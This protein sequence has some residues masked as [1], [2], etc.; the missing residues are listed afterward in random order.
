MR[1]CFLLAVLAL[2]STLSSPAVRAQAPPPWS[3]YPLGVG[4]VWEYAEPGTGN[5]L[6]VHIARDT[7]ALGRPYVVQV[8]DRFD[9][10]GDTLPPPLYYHRTPLRYDTASTQVRNIIPLDPDEEQVFPFAPCPLGAPGGQ[11]VRCYD[12]AS[13]YGVREFIGTLTI[14]DTVLTGVRFKEFESTAELFTYAAE[15]GEVEFLSKIEPYRYLRYARVGG[16][17]YGTPRFPVAAGPGSP[18][19]SISLVVSPNPAR[20]AVAATL[21]LVRPSTV[22]VAVYDALGRRVALLHSGGPAAGA[23]AFAWAAPAPGVYFVRVA[24][25]GF[26]LARALTV[27][28]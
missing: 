12:G 16:V 24:G 21:T 2:A 17:E 5:T 19:S 3:Y 9:S 4:D 18:A 13:W 15:F 8:R 27:V 20:D 14:G 26:R 6:R 23:H 11:P 10:A 28:R 1:A 25:P 7:F 22:E